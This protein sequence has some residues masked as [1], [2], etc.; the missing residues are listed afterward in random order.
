MG[1][2]DAGGCVVFARVEGGVSD[3]WGLVSRFGGKGKGK[4]MM[5]ARGAKEV[6]WRGGGEKGEAHY[7]L[8][9]HPKFQRVV[10]LLQF[11]IGGREVLD[12]FLVVSFR[13]CEVGGFGL[14]VFDAGG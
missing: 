9:F 3:G 13:F 2:E 12:S 11:C 7:L 1:V 10:F 4:G 5:I 8:C 6:C 14:Q